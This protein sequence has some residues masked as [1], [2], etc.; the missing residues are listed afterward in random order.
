MLTALNYECRSMPVPCTL[1]ANCLCK[2]SRPFH[3]YTLV[4]IAPVAMAISRKMK[5]KRMETAPMMASGSFMGFAPS[6][7]LAELQY[8]SGSCSLVRNF[9]W[10]SLPSKSAFVTCMDRLRRD[11]RWHDRAND[12]SLEHLLGRT[13][14]R[15]GQVAER[16]RADI[17]VFAG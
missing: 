7:S 16:A 17:M 2:L 4:S 5:G 6:R 10:S 11:V 12:E 9:F 1:R 3:L 15:L 14:R 13:L 8:C